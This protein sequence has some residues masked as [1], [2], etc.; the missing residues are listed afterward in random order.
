MAI[1]Y[2]KMLLLSS[3]ANISLYLVMI[4]IFLKKIGKN[5]FTHTNAF[6]NSLDLI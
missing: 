5:W 6:Q 4:L 2:L 3:A 1:L